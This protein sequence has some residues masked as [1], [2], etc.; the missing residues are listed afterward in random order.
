[1]RNATKFTHGGGGRIL[2]ATRPAGDVPDDTW[3]DRHGNRIEPG[4]LSAI[5]EAFE[6][7]AA[8]SA[9]GG[10]GLGLA[11]SQAVVDAH[12]GRI[13]AASDGPGTGAS[14]T[15]DLPRAVDGPRH[16]PAS[17]PEPSEPPRGDPLPAAPATHPRSAAVSA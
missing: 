5:F 14:F 7:G 6:Q 9:F 4:R 16:V 10:L 11:I 17:A 12:G 2:I 15:V 13:R 1:V 3:S 8:G